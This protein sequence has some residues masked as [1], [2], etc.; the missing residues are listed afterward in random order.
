[1]GTIVAEGKELREFDGRT[2][3]MERSLAPACR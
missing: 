1:V 2:Y 3:V